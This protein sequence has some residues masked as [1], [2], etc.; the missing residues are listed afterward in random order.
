MGDVQVMHA[1]RVGRARQAQLATGVSAQQVGHQLTLVDE[2]FGISGQAVTVERRTAQRT[3]NVRT[4]VEGQPG[5][6]Q[7]L[8]D[9]PI[10]ER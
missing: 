10:E 6:E 1:A 5:G 7:A 2:R 3:W 9:G 4:L 8:A